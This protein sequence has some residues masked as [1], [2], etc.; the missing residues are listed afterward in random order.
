MVH[1]SNTDDPIDF[2][3]SALKRV[4]GNLLDLAEA[5]EFEVIVQG[6]NCHGVMGSG[7]AKEIR[8]RYPE[9][10]AVD[11]ATP[12][13]DYNKLGNYTVVYDE[14][15]IVNAYTQFNT[16]KYAGEDVFEY[17][18]FQLIL[19]KLS[20]AYP[21]CSFG[22]P[23][24]GMGLAGGNRERIIDMLEWFA[25]EIAKTGGSATLVEFG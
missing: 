5:G 16:A 6:C 18:A 7:I 11:Q 14:F 15:V 13:G 10:Y 9:A 17:V 3:K 22:F 19:Q 2:P 8:D 24:I 21:N 12:A 20:N 4:K 23:Y 1:Y 25:V